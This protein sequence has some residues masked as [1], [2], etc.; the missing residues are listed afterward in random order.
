MRGV[1]LYRA[2]FPAARPA[3]AATLIRAAQALGLKAR[4]VAIGPGRLTR[5][6]LPAIASLRN[7]AMV[8]LA[9]ASD[10]QVLIQ[11]PA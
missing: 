3:D 2:L 5:I 6:P 11:D 10:D 8:V 1:R 9:R 4:Q 7:G